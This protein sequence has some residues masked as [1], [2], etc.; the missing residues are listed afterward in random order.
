MGLYFMAAIVLLLA[1]YAFSGSM[2]ST[3]ITY[4][5]VQDLFQREQVKSF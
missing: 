4:A 1:F 2:G 3:G 5:Q